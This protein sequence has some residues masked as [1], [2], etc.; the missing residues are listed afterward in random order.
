MY[1]KKV[2]FIDIGAFYITYYYGFFD[3]LFTHYGIEKFKDV[4]FEGVSAGGQIS[5]SCIFTIH[6][7]K[8]MKYWFKKGPKQLVSSDSLR[9]Q[10]ATQFFREF[11]ESS[12]KKTTQEQKDAIQKYFSTL[13]SSHDYEPYWFR[14]ID[15]SHKFA[16]AISSTGNIPIVGST[17]PILHDD[18][19]LWDG[20]FCKKFG[21]YNYYKTN[22]GEKKLIIS[23][24]KD[25]PR[26]ENARVL[27]LNKYFMYSH[28]FSFLPFLLNSSMGSVY[29]DELYDIGYNDAQQKIA[30]IDT[31]IQYLFNE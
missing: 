8:N 1:M 25:I 17:S 22:P 13:S 20:Y 12:Y 26:V 6:G 16:S 29:C 3:F 28:F 31:F 23:W 19:C 15:T 4:Y 9:N 7:L 27:D 14:N 5:A 2:I 18:C 11:S 10:K 24:E 21:G 30:E